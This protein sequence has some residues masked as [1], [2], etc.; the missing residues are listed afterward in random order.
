MNKKL[1]IDIIP[2]IIIIITLGA[3]FYLN[4]YD[5]KPFAQ[6][7]GGYPK[8]TPFLY[9]MRYLIYFL[10][11]FL[12]IFNI[13]YGVQTANLSKLTFFDSGKNFLS[14]YQQR[15]L[16]IQNGVIKKYNVAS[17]TND[18]RAKE[19][20]DYTKAFN[21]EYGN[22]TTTFC[23]MFAPCTCCGAA[24]YTSSSCTADVIKLPS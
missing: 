4:S 12:I 16:D 17:L 11:I 20:D 19:Y 8:G 6:R 13:Y 3:Y 15:T 21:A 24:G 1:L 18:P 5:N 22:Y 2:Y 14:S 7:G 10:F 9:Q 23:T